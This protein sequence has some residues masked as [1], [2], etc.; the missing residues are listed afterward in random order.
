MIRSD[1]ADARPPARIRVV[2]ED[3]G[4]GI[5]QHERLHLFERFYRGSRAGQRA[6]SDG[7]GLGL[8]LVAEHV[9]LHGGSVWIEDAPGGGSRFIVELPV[10]LRRLRRGACREPSDGA[11]WPPAAAV[12]VAGATAACGIPTS[13]TPTAIA[14]A[15]VPFHL[16]N[17][18][19][20]TTA[21][22]GRPARA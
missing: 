17:P 9:R 10:R 5:P 22:P 18:V 16:L 11:R 21:R 8:S 13:G 1:P 7:T 4:P 15:D 2:V 19:T 12:L 3:H 14:K 20:P 6:S